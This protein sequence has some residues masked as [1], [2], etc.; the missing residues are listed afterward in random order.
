M[1]MERSRYFM[2]SVAHTHSLTNFDLFREK[3]RA[4]LRQS[5]RLQQ[6]LA[7]ALGIDAQ[8]LSRKLH[9]AKNFFLTHFEVKQIIKVLASGDAISTRADA[10]ELLSL[11]GLRE[12]SFSDQ[13]WNA[14]P[15]KRLEPTP[16]TGAAAPVTNT[17]PAL[18]V[19]STSLIG[20]EGQVRMLLD[21]LR[22]PSVR[23]LTLLGTGGVG[24]TRLALE[25]IRAI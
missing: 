3:V 13:E 11:M 17:S 22:Q 2:N 10:I 20:R 25:V 16:H 23:L 8:V 5:G 1:L 9:S 6:E 19:P 18:V 12:E 21:Q 7:S 14:E 15:L 4:A 24:K